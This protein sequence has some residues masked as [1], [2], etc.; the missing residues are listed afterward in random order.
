MLSICSHILYTDRTQDY[1]LVSNVDFKTISLHNNLR[2]ISLRSL[3]ASINLL[4]SQLQYLDDE[5]FSCSMVSDNFS[6]NLLLLGYVSRAFSISILHNQYD[7]SSL[8]A[9]VVASF[10]LH[11]GVSDSQSSN[12]NILEIENIFSTVA[13][14]FHRR[15]VNDTLID[16]VSRFLSP[17]R[18]LLPNR[19]MK[20]ELDCDFMSFLRCDYYEVCRD[21]VKMYFESNL[22]SV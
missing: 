2:N 7:F 8:L 19:G 13:K 10:R 9:A 11:S 15:R 21:D 3:F 14:P 20:C 18:K 22:R 6:K 4:Y 5:K 1:F 17:H 16:V 12:W